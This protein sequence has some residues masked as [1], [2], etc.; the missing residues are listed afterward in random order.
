MYIPGDAEY[1]ELSNAIQLDVKALGQ[2]MMAGKSV[3]D[4]VKDLNAKWTEARK[5]K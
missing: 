4:I 5:N 2:E 3:D 1:T